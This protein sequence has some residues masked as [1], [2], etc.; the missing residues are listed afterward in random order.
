MLR[1]DKFVRIVHFSTHSAA[2]FEHAYPMFNANESYYGSTQ[3]TLE[4]HFRLDL[5]SI[6]TRITN[7]LDPSKGPVRRIFEERKAELVLLSVMES[8]GL[9]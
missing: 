7:M 3:Y 4:T 1:R 6:R 9:Y 8:R 5:S 2:E